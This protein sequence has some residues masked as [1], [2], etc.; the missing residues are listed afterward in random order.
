MLAIF[1]LDGTLSDHEHR[2]G[3]VRH[4]P[5]DF[6]AYNA[7]CEGDPVIEEIAAVARAMHVSGHDV[8]IWTGRSAAVR[9]ETER[10]LLAHSIFYDRL[11]MRPE[12]DYR[13][14]WELKGEWL[15]DA[16]PR[17]TL[18]FDDDV[19]MVDWWREMGLATCLVGITPRTSTC[20]G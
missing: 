2:V 7:L 12:G 8:E 4:Y 19:Y 14:A 5:P 9:A 3:L 17:P 15:A 11:L 20:P 1:D 10:W 13:P 18:V 6:D 16:D